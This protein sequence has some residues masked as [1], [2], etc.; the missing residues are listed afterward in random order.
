V[1]R[2]PLL[3]ASLA[4]TLAAGCDEDRTGDVAQTDRVAPVP[5]SAEPPPRR[6]PTIPTP[7]PR[8]KGAVERGQVVYVSDGDTVG[9]RIDGEVRRIRL[10]GIDAPE[11]KDPDEP[12]GC[13]GP[14]A[15]A[16]VRSLLPLGM[17][18]TVVSDPTQDRVDRFGRPLAYV[19]RP[20]ERRPVNERL[21]AD[22]A[23]RVYVYRRNRPFRRLGAF[24]KAEA[25]ARAARRGLWARCGG[26][27]PSSP[28]S[29]S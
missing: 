23:A 12:V 16:R 15:S 20:R 26:P 3:V 14:Q 10:L 17:T 6:V 22:G 25:S 24:R 13:Y 11:T 29:G 2:R 1:V 19:F 27:P 21:L 28:G 7:E 18:V 9:V 4:L 8:P 5:T